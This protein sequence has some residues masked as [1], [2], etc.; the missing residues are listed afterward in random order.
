MS[1]KLRRRPVVANGAGGQALLEN[2]RTLMKDRAYAEIKQCLLRGELAGGSFLAERQLAEKLGMSKTPVRAAL[3]RLEAEGF[4]TV[5]PQQGIIIRDLTVHEIADQYEIRTALETYTVRTLAG[6]LTA[7]QV[8]RLQG[9][10]RAQ[11]RLRKAN[12]VPRWVAL[13]AEFH[14]LFCEFLGNQE[15]L[16]VISGLREKIHRVTTKVFQMNP[17]RMGM[18]YEEHGQIADAVISGAGA[19]AARLIE[20]HLEVGKQ[21]LLSPRRG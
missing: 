4:V 1:R 9:N 12:D 16:R 8:A 11:E 21:F 18:S 14:T 20:L 15:I 19:R 6:K 13:D 17:G 10:L 2:G 7:A 3:E 5:S